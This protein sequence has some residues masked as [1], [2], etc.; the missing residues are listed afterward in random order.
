[1]SNYRQTTI[2]ETNTEN[3]ID[4]SRDELRKFIRSYYHVTFQNK[5]T[6]KNLDLGITIGFIGEGKKKTAY[7]AAM[8]QKK[9]A[10]IMILDQLL[11]HAKFT[12]WGNRKETDK[13]EVLGYL[14]FKVK[15]KIDGKLIHFAINVEVRNNG[16]FHYSLDE[17]R[18]Q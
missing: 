12:N 17:N 13:P 1:M 14:N 15:L 10:A 8:Y 5:V 7:G 9:A 11:I 18:Y 6:V 2:P 16:K 4:K 3:L